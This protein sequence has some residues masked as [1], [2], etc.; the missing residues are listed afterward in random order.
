M[1]H[2]LKLLAISICLLT[3]AMY[4][5]LPNIPYNENYYIMFNFFSQKASLVLL[6]VMNSYR[7]Q[8]S[9]MIY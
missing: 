8:K 1:K 5:L 4:N 3:C 6:K 9:N 7:S 2:S